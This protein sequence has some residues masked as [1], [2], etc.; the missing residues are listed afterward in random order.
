MNKKGFLILTLILGFIVIP[1]LTM[2]YSIFV[3]IGAA[4]VV[5]I[6][7]DKIM[8]HKGIQ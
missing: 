4:L 5:G 3:S 2:K 6:I 7:L 8:K 1:V